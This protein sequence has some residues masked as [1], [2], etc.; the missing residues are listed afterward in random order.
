MAKKEQKRFSYASDVKN[1]LDIM[2]D[3]AIHSAEELADELNRTKDRV[4]LVVKKARQ[5][6]NNGDLDVDC[7]IYSTRGGY[8][9]DEKPEHVMHEA[10]MRYRMGIGVILNGAHV[11]ST[12]KRIAIKDFGTLQIELKPKMLSMGKLIK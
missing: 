3:G 5:K 7:W 12:A 6:F 9:I 8:T 1:L 2:Q 11:F 10:R 4:R